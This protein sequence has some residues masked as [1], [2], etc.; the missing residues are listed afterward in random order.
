MTA[1]RTTYKPGQHPILRNSTFA[2]PQ[3]GSITY[4]A[5]TGKQPKAAR[6]HGYHEVLAIPS[7]GMPPASNRLNGLFQHLLSRPRFPV[8]IL[9]DQ[10]CE[11]GIRQSLSGVETKN[12]KFNFH[13]MGGYTRSETPP[14]PEAE[15][16]KIR[17]RVLEILRARRITQ[18][19]IANLIRA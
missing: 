2:R 11:Q 3:S 12:P 6:Q 19:Q 9:S 18:P 8:P 4:H 16:E 5:Q 17:L 13:L 15:S 10:N 14:I 1:S 7:K